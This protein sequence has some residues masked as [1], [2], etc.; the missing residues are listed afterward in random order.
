MKIVVSLICLAVVSVLTLI[1]I[2]L[3]HVWLKRIISRAEFNER[4]RKRMRES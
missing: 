1:V 3:D 4:L 2:W